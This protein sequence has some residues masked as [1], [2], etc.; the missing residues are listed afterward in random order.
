[1]GGYKD[2][3]KK[4]GGYGDNITGLLEAFG[5]DKWDLG[6]GRIRYV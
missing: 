4:G 3:L 5:S 6:L 2:V 1:M